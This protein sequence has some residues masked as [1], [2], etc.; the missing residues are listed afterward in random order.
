MQQA[1]R[2]VVVGAIL[3]LTMSLIAPAMASAEAAAEEATSISWLSYRQGREQ[4][5]QTGK[6]LLINFTADWCRYCRK[7]KKETYTEPEVI[8][9]VSEHFV[10]VMVDTQKERQIATE[11]YVR[12]LPTIW[13]LTSEGERISNLPGFVDAPTY[14]QVLRYIASGTYQ[15]MDFKAYLDAAPAA[16]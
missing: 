2:Y 16:E 11:Y 10:P 8:A 1:S 13:F 14:L 6:M 7:M 15:Q 12:G 4:A 9:Y 5:S 3:C